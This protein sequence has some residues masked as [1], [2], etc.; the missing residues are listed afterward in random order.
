[1]K[2]VVSTTPLQRL[3]DC[4]FWSDEMNGRSIWAALGQET[5]G[6]RY[7]DRRTIVILQLLS[8]VI[9]ALCYVNI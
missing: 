4:V 5:V 6:C 7:P 2:G 1:M 3:I 9:I 8:T